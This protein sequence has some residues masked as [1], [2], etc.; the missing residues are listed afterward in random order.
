MRSRSLA[1]AIVLLLVVA[2]CS[3]S[4][5]VSPAPSPALPVADLTWS[6]TTVTGSTFTGASLKGKPA[7]LWFWAPWCPIC[8]SQ[9][10]TVDHLVQRYQGRVS[11]VG[12]G[13]LDSAEA[14]RKGREVRAGVTSIVDDGGRLWAT[15]EVSQQAVF[16]VLDAQGHIPWN[17]ATNPGNWNEVGDKIA[18]VAG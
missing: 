7:L 18:A 8:A 10:P 4:H 9:I 17:S 2:A 1:A 6:A 15:F 13:S 3:S 14:I 16:V 11:F 5:P 12:I